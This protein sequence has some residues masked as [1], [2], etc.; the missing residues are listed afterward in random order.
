MCRYLWLDLH[1]PL[2][3]CTD[4]WFT[5][6]SVVEFH[7]RGREN[8]PEILFFT[9]YTVLNLE[10]LSLPQLL[11]PSLDSPI[12]KDARLSRWL[13][14]NAEWWMRTIKCVS[15]KIK[16]CFIQMKPSCK[17]DSFTKICHICY[18]ITVFN[19]ISINFIYFFL[20]MFRWGIFIP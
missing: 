18:M 12:F 8:F 4:D 19:I 13:Y 5:Y 7:E 20:I 16:S 14:N 11:P 2:Y 15:T 1:F 10:I 3:A 6:R 17:N 9:F